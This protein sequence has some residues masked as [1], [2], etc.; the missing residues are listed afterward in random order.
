MSG[1]DA[2]GPLP[3]LQDTL[4]DADTLERLFTDVG[5]CA[6]L[7]EIMFKGGE[8]R[9]AQSARRDLT[10]AGEALLAGAVVAVQLRYRYRGVEWWDT[11]L[12]EQAGVRLVRMQ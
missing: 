7:V 8:Q 1:D 3:E 5:A 6:E 2:R 11:L 4:L 9:Y 12:R 10:L